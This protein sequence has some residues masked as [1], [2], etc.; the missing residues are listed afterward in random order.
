MKV[1]LNEELLWVEISNGDHRAFRLLFERY[2]ERMFQYAHRVLGSREDAEEVVQELFIHLWQRREQLPVLQ[3]VPA[4]LFKA[5]KNRLLNA[6]ARKRSQLDTLETLHQGVSQL[7]ATELPERKNTEQLIRTLARSL[8]EKMQQVYILH[9]FR[10]LSIAEIAATTGNSEQTIRNQVNSAI[11]KL[12][13]A[14]RSNV[15][16][17]LLIISC[18][19][20]C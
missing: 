2:W 16:L 9:Q 7:S 14:Y 18:F 3:S 19:F 15:H 10:G 5:L 1:E 17:L 11:K 8:P 4:Y 12:S 20:C 6:L 13:L